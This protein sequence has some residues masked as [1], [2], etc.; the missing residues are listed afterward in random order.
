MREHDDQQ[1]EMIQQLT[2]ELEKT[3]QNLGQNNAAAEIL[4]GMIQ[5]GEAEMD[6]EGNVRVVR[7][8]IFEG[9][10]HP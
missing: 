10:Q 3:K 4:T 5:R 7:Q 1:Q 9:I 2:R 6:V 8:D